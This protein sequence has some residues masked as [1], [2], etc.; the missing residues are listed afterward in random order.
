MLTS[1]KIIFLSVR[2][3]SLKYGL[4]LIKNNYS[5]YVFRLVY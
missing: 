4:N 1:L 2:K 5:G 3:K